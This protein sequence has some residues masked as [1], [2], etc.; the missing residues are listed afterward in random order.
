[1]VG[2]IF[3]YYAL[4]FSV[5]GYGQSDLFIA[6]YGHAHGKICRADDFD[7]VAQFLHF[8]TNMFIGAH[9][10]V[11]LR[12]PGIADNQEFHRVCRA[13]LQWSFVTGIDICR[14]QFYSLSKAL[15]VS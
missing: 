13:F 8:L 14:C 1:M 11:N 6:G 2:V 3:F 12:V 15:K 4:Q 5:G 7:S 9:N 10:A